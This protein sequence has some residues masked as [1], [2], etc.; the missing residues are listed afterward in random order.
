MYAKEEMVAHPRGNIARAPAWCQ[1][2]LSSGETYRVGFGDFGFFVFFFFLIDLS[3]T[4]PLSSFASP[5]PP[6]FV[7]PQHLHLES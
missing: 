4:N 6:L 1:L 5:V 3:L 7:P 2:Q